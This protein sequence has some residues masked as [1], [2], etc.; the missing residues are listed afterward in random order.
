MF[1]TGCAYGYLRL[2]KAVDNVLVC[3]FLSMA[4]VRIKRAVRGRLLDAKY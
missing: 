2:Q 1:I 4:H 3:G